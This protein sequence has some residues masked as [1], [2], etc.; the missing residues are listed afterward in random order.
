MLD[1]ELKVS[2]ST[3]CDISWKKKKLTREPNVDEVGLFINNDNTDLMGP[4]CGTKSVG[5]QIMISLLN[6][7]FR[8]GMNISS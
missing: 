1:F 6:G 3:I 5:F 7:D 8:I 2:R 4:F